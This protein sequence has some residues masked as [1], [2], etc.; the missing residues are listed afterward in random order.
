MSKLDIIV[1]GKMNRYYLGS[2]PE[3]LI[4]KAEKIN[5]GSEVDPMFDELNIFFSPMVVDGDNNIEIVF[6]GNS[7]YIGSV[8]HLFKDKKEYE[9]GDPI[10]TEKIR[11][12]SI[13]TNSIQH[14]WSEDIDLDNKQS[15]LDSLEMNGAS[16]SQN[17]WWIGDDVI[18]NNTYEDKLEEVNY[19]ER[20][21]LIEYGNFKV[22]Y[23]IDNIE[24]F[25]LL[26]L[27]W[28]FDYG[29]YEERDNYFF[30]NI[31]IVNNSKIHQ[32]DEVIENLDQKQIIIER[33]WPIDG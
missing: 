16:F 20:L 13:L 9:E 6:D 4:Q 8:S 32:L 3:T 25:D 19:E 26:S 29:L 14:S 24:K 2:A 33:D 30:S 21:S 5:S 10:E 23:S 28:N 31:F 27:I 22:E 15:F 1:Q 17:G 12:N 18:I 11:H 7:K